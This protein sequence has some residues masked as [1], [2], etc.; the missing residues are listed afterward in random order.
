MRC[1]SG[2]RSP[3]MKSSCAMASNFSSTTRAP[4]ICAAPPSTTGT[5]SPAPVFTSRMQT[6]RGRADAAHLSKQ[7]VRLENKSFPRPAPLDGSRL[8][9]LRTSPKLRTVAAQKNELLRL[10]RRD[11]SPDRVRFRGVAGQ[12][13]HFLA[14]GAAAELSNSQEAPQDRARQPG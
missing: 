1:R 4:I 12:L 9:S 2:R 7:P 5:N 3:A 6:Q 14:T 13:L 11:P 8:L 10:G